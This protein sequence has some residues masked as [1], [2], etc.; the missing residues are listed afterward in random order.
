MGSVFTNLRWS[1]Y[2]YWSVGRG[3]YQQHSCTGI[4]IRWS[5]SFWRSRKRKLC[6]KA[7]R[8]RRGRRGSRRRRWWRRLLHLFVYLPTSLEIVL[9]LLNCWKT[10]NETEVI[11]IYSRRSTASTK[12]RYRTEEKTSNSRRAD[13]CPRCRVRPGRR[14]SEEEV[15]CCQVNHRRIRYW[16]QPK[17]GSP[18]Q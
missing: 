15:G 14:G 11:I 3:R 8:R 13:G 7:S 17:L 4:F 5:G 18:Y 12:S 16:S 6:W 10:S 9:S 2:H 1:F